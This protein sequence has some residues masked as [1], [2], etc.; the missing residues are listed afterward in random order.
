MIE[1]DGRMCCVFSAELGKRTREVLEN[2]SFGTHQQK[3]MIRGTFNF[4]LFPGY[5]SY[6]KRIYVV[7]LL[8][9][10]FFSGKRGNHL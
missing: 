6:W 4:F 5:N 9:K 8:R 7:L 1:E 10:L 3:Q 2:P